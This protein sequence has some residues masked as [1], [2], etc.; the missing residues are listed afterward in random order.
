MANDSV[1]FSLIGLDSLLG[2]FDELSFDA[3][4]KGGRAALRK[5]A[6]LLVGYA[7][8]G[9]E[10]FDD[11]ETGRS[12]ASN[13]DLRWDG[14]HN[15]QA[16]DLAFRVGVLKG[17]VLPKKGE[18]PDFN[19][20]APT[21]HWRLKE[22]GTET[23]PADPFMRNA[24]ADHI[25]EITNVVLTEFEKSIDRAIKRAKKKKALGYVS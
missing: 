21:P 12:I 24:L 19:P 16:G 13:I 17:A 4:K 2:K 18:E 3:R 11:L 9:A 8:E 15:K 10:R 14:K 7:R 1:D 5:G 22:F 25:G 20:G 6:Q 23:M